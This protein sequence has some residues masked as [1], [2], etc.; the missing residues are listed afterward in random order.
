MNSSHDTHRAI[1]TVS[2]RLVASP[3]ARQPASPRARQPV[4]KSPRQQATPPASY[5]IR[6]V[7]PAYIVGITK[8]LPSRT[9][10]GQRWVIVFIWV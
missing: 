6:V 4:S 3:P 1:G 10:L 7:F 5:P 9:P 8:A 2:S